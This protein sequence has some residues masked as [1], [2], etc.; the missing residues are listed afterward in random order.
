MFTNKP[1][2]KMEQMLCR[3]QVYRSNIVM[4][5]TEATGQNVFAKFSGESS[6]VT[7]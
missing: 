6:R 4:E 3:V 1:L 7:G 2:M 5:V